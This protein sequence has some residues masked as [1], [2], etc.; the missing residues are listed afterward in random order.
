MAYERA[1]R[2]AVPSGRLPAPGQDPLSPSLATPRARPR[3]GECPLE[4][5]G[6]ASLHLKVQFAASAPDYGD[7]ERRTRL[8]AQRFREMQAKAAF[9]PHVRLIRSAY[10]IVGDDN[11]SLACGRPMNL[12]RQHA[13]AAGKGVLERIGR[14]L[15]HHEAQR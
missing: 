4:A 13:N 6:A 5:H 11:L 2:P 10:A 3:G 8:T 15:V 1:K 9:L 7:G 12:Q 14:Q